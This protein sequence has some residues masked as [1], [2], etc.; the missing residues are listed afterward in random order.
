[1]WRGSVNGKEQSLSIF[2]TADELGEFLRGEVAKGRLA[3]IA[4]LWADGLE[5][6]WTLMQEGEPPARL[7]A[8]VSLCASTPLVRCAPPRDGST[9][10]CGTGTCCACDRTFAGHSRRL[11]IDWFAGTCRSSLASTGTNSAAA[12]RAKLKHLLAEALY[13]DDSAID[14]DSSFVDLG[15]DSI[16]AVELVKRL[17]DDLQL[18]LKATRLYDYANIRSLGDYLAQVLGQ[19]DGVAITI[20]PAADPVP[21][22]A[23]MSEPVNT[24]P[25]PVDLPVCTSAPHATRSDSQGGTA[26][27]PVSAEEQ[28]YRRLKQLIGEAIGLTESQLDDELDLLELGLEM[29]AAERM[30]A[31]ILSE[32]GVSLRGAE[33]LGVPGVRQLA[34][35]IE[36]LRS[37][38]PAAATTLPASIPSPV[39]PAAPVPPPHADIA[40]IGMA[41][42]FPGAQNLDEFWTNLS[43][44]VD[45]VVEVPAERWSVEAF[46]D[47]TLGTPNKTYCRKGGY[48]TGIENFDPLFFGISPHEAEVMDPQQR[49]FLEEAWKALEDAGYSDADLSNQACAIYVGAGPGDYQDHLA[50]AEGLPLAQIGMGNVNSILAARLSYVLNLKGAAVAVDTACSSSLVALHLAC[51]SLRNGECDLALAGG[52]CVL[53]SPQMHVL[54]SQ[55]RMLAPD[56]KCKTFDNRADGF[57]PAEGVGVVVVKL[58]SQALADGDRIHAVV[59]G[60]GINQDGKTNGITAPN[61]RSQ[62]DLQLTVYDRYQIDPGT[63]TLVEAHGTGTKLGDPIEI[64]ALTES[65]QRFTAA[66]NFCARRQRQK[67]HRTCVSPRPASPGC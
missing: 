10:R 26:D 12:L 3:K 27:F 40:I 7:V 6:D 41:G 65:F 52:V 37:I 9:Y 25:P 50:Q 64:E 18:S 30:A 17:N 1:M 35:T 60:T 2:E 23:Q 4:R 36:R 48:L 58:L 16:L 56:G 24:V 46:F 34:Q 62:A 20:P 11:G 5:I 59:R 43:Q 28:V 54:T 45:S 47:P 63:I 21:A 67:Q 51:Q 32:W 22:A 15:L 29:V 8:D 44:G 13:L 42:R 39:A 19:T 66:R 55:S 38:G 53:N 49:L 14:E 57:V 61:A 33:L 31:H